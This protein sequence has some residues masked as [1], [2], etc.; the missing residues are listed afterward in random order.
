MK[1]RSYL[2]TT[3]FQYNIYIVLILEI[4]MEPN[5]VGVLQVSMKLYLTGDLKQGK[6]MPYSFCYHTEPK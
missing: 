5:N 6:E 1:T 4:A 2:S 3:V